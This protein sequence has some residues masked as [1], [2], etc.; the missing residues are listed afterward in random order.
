MKQ[1]TLKLRGYAHNVNI[2]DNSNLQK[3]ILHIMLLTL[4]ILSFFY[5]FFLGNMVFNIVERKALEVSADTLSNEVGNLELQYLTASQKINLN[6][7]YSMGFKETKTE[8]TTRKTLGSLS[9]AKN[10]I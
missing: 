5:V 6:L 4:G 10:E 7:A 9:I 2:V 1:A 3:R 8:F